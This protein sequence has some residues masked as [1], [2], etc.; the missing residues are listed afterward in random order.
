MGFSRR[1]FG[2]AANSEA[3]M[4]E[5]IKALDCS[6]DSNEKIELRNL[7]LGDSHWDR[8]HIKPGRPSIGSQIWSQ[9]PAGLTDVI[10]S[11][12]LYKICSWS[13]YQFIR[14]GIIDDRIK[15]FISAAKVQQNRVT[16][17]DIVNAEKQWA[18]VKRKQLIKAYAQK[19][20]TTIVDEYEETYTAALKAG[21]SAELAAQQAD[22]KA[23]ETYDANAQTDYTDALEDDPSGGSSSQGG[24]SIGPMIAGVASL[25][26]GIFATKVI[27]GRLRG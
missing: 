15:E 22:A 17:D 11:S 2:A 26:L 21:A 16:L 7:A 8:Q 20:G 9:I 12:E 14:S 18:Q 25:G 23:Q 5:F 24:L 27:I 1:N 10:P 19:L 3:Q 6:A 4:E 13:V